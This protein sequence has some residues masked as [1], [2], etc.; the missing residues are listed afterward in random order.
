MNE[1]SDMTRNDFVYYKKYFVIFVSGYELGKKVISK[2]GV[3]HG[4]LR[5]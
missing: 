1:L 3:A 4:F 5:N 2:K